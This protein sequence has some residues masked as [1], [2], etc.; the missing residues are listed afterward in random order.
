VT[1]PILDLDLEKAGVTSII[2]ATGYA[3]DFS[4][5]DVDAFDEKGKPKH[6]RGV[7]KEPGIY[8]LGLPWLSR[9]GSAFIWGVWHD[10]R[11]IAD[12]IVTQRKYLAYRDASQRHTGDDRDGAHAESRVHKVSEMGVN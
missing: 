2:W 4:W 1:H 6:Q 5:L 10:A 7:S 12:H 3:V 11:H 8:F 9:R